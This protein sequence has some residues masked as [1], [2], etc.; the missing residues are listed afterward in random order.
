MI[1]DEKYVKIVSS[2][3]EKVKTEVN[4]NNQDITITQNGNY[5]AEPPYTGFGLV[6]VAVPNGTE[7]L[8]VTQNG[9]FRPSGANIGFDEVNVNVDIP[10]LITKTITANGTYNASADN[11]DGYSSVTVNVPMPKYYGIP[12]ANWA[13]LETEETGTP[14]FTGLTSIHEGFC[15]NRFD[16]ATNLVGVANFDT[17]T[18]IGAYALAGAFGRTNLTGVSFENVSRIQHNGMEYAFNECENLTGT[19]SFPSLINIQ[20]ND[21]RCFEGAFS[22]AG[23]KSANFSALTT[24]AASNAFG[25][26]FEDSSLESINFNALQSITGNY[27]L[28]A[29]F[30]G[31]NLT[32]VS[33]QNLTTI[34]GQGALQSTFSGCSSL[35]SLSFPALT[36]VANESEEIFSWMLDSVVGCTVHFPSNMQAT[37]GNWTDVV[38][39]FGGTNTVVLFDLPTSQM[40]MVQA[41]VYNRTPSK[42]TATS[43]C[44]YRAATALGPEKALYVPNTA[45]PQVGDM[46]YLDAACTQTFAVIQH[47]G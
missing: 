8:S 47:I 4:V 42:D 10:E 24:I 44:W 39:G 35:Q 21:E 12:A 27:G 15:N 43:W 9:T 26:C 13:L 33:F 40:I 36:T 45:L 20:A 25:S 37:I 19:V 22:Y 46:T 2:P 29:A 16:T 3:A 30:L 1:K 14:D 17:L 32:N 7:R 28:T 41:S 31:T 11:A 34:T 18:L 5:Q 38:S 23:V 6:S